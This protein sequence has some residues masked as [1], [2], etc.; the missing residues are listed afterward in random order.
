[1]KTV[2][3]LILWIIALPGLVRETDAMAQEADTAGY[4]A[5]PLTG[6]LPEHP[7]ILLLK[8]EEAALMQQVLKEPVWA[9]IHRGIIT[10]CDSLI[11]LPPLERIQTG[12]R[13]LFVS[14]EC[15]RRVFQLSYAYRMTGEEKYLRRAEK[16][17]LAVSAFSDWNP[18]HFLDVAEMTMGVAIGYDWLFNALSGESRKTIREAII[19]KG[20]KPSL[21]EEYN[22][23]LR[24]EHNWNQVCNAG[25]TYGALAIAEDD[26]WLAGDIIGRAVET[27]PAA[28]FPYGPDGTYPEGFTYWEYGTNFNAMFLSAVEKALGTDYGLP[29]S[30]GFSRTAGFRLNI[31]GPLGLGH[32]WSDCGLRERLSPALFW[33]ADR[34][35]D[36]AVLW[37]QLRLLTD[38]LSRDYL[39]NRLLPALLIWGADVRAGN[40]QAPGNKLWIGQG[41]NP[42]GLMRTSWED[43]DAVFIGFKTGSASENHA[44]LDAGS[45]VLDMLGERWAMD[46]GMQNYHSLESKGVDLWNGAQESQ[47]WQ[48]FRYNNFTHNTL[49]IDSQLQRVDGYA[50]I[51]AWSDD[52]ARLS[53][54]SDLS[55]IYKGQA[56]AVKRGI[57]IVDSAYVVVRD[58]V[59]APDRDITLRWTLLTP[60]RARI[61][62]GHTVEL[63]QNGKKLYLV[64]DTS[65]PVTL[66]TWPTDPPHDYDAPNPGTQLVGFEARIPADSEQDFNAWFSTDKQMK[67]LDPL[68]QWPGQRQTVPAATQVRARD[69]EGIRLRV[70]TDLLEP[71]VDEQEISRLMNAVQ[72]DGSW[73]D[74][75]YRDV[76]RTGFEHGDHLDNLIELSRAWKKPAS[77]F[78]RDPELKNVISSALDFWLA[79]DFISDNWWWNE[80]GTPGRM[81]DIL[82]LMDDDLSEK[83]RSEGMRIAGRANL[84]AWGARPGGDLIQIA[85]MR[86]K[87]ALFD[88]DPELLERV[89]KVMAGEIRLT[90]GRGLKPDL[91][92]HHRKDNVISTLSY[93]AG[94]ARSFA[95]WAAKTAGT[96]F[97][98]PDASMELLVDYY[99]DGIRQSMVYGKYPDPGAKNR[100]VSRKNALA[101]AEPELA[102]NLLRATNYREKELE[103]AVKT[104]GNRFFW[105]S[106]YFTHQRPGYFTSVRMHST[107]GNNMEYPHNEEGLKNHHYADGANF[108]SRTGQE[109]FNIFPVWDWQKIPGTTIVQKPVFPDWHELVKEGISEFAGGVTDGEYGAAA[110]DFKSPHDSL[111]ARKSWFFFDSAYVCL[112]AG[113]SSWEEHPVATTLNQCL[114]NGEVVV[115]TRNRERTLR[116]G[117]HTF[118][119]VSWV[120]HDSI[121]YLFP[122]PAGVHL[123]NTTATGSWQE[124]NHHTWAAKE[125][126]VQK[127]VFSL[128]LDHG[129]QPQEAAYQYIVVPGISASGATSY[130]N[131]E[132]NLGIQILA[133]TP[134]LQAVTHTRLNNTQVV[135]YE[136]GE[137]RISDDLTLTAG[138]PCMI[139][140]Q[141]DGKAV[142]KITVSDPSRNLE[143]IHF[144]I[145]KPIDLSNEH[146]KT[147]WNAE[148][149]CTEFSVDL[150][151]AGYAGKSVNIKL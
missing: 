62:D 131:P 45:F 52:P 145:N 57:A 31:V 125:A 89:M 44:H 121:A 83:Q 80:M 103:K 73:P 4:T 47:R 46:F 106:E 74:I 66:K 88:R 58:E 112:G 39:E 18:S 19:T 82:L 13:L 115:K 70:I 81:I 50:R 79:H 41:P 92:F 32:N 135:F 109:Y 60:A 48:I 21:N 144:E 12:R 139:M 37:N 147:N 85:S 14:R 15:L 132:Q 114:L 143:E 90:T 101:P 93:G 129:S 24:A 124:I 10:R 76:S 56:A 65:S 8:G 119:K 36:P 6:A 111:R 117:E 105:H 5:V 128:W 61:L 29:E 126:E 107:R 43:P 22:R 64:F 118:E 136:P 75:D 134:A 9:S 86:G 149:A 138:N 67:P 78:Y 97:D 2:K 116:R 91:S 51:D 142:Q 130:E 23:F 59:R 33:F 98:L 34:Q 151:K 17:L 35:Q 7:R 11:T 104:Q 95:Y 120:F 28:M 71:A 140:V 99:L 26:P 1:M 40:I 122:S 77:G 108:I 27:I 113:I 102:R 20:L 16:E 30:P 110:F 123:G 84:E 38:T 87:Q 68:A 53:L 127:D 63:S 55:D 141:T 49:T 54:V 146:V 137:L 42:I 69:L 96:S 3:L 25:M 94:Y 150:P 133:N 72:P 100:S 148:K